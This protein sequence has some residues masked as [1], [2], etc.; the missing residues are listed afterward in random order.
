MITTRHHHQGQLP[1]GLA[2]LLIE[3]HADAYADQLDDPFVQR[4][5]WFAKLWSGYPDFHCVIAYDGEEPVGFAYGAPL[6]EGKEWWRGHLEEEPADPST[7]AVSEIMVRPRWRKQGISSLLH[8]ELI[9]SKPQALATLLV[10]TTHP[11]VQALYESWDYR[12]VGEQQPFEDAPVY[13]VMI[14]PI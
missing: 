2:D 13:A 4:F 3:V 11:R 14:R 12:K 9:A 5:P 1:A 10:D 6:G 7:F 8:T